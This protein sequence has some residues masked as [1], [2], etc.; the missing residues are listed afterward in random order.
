MKHDKKMLHVK[1][2]LPG[3]L[4]SFYDIHIKVHIYSHRLSRYRTICQKKKQRATW[5][6]T[7]CL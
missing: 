7:S 5:E 4:P 1:L 6:N 3:K 2:K